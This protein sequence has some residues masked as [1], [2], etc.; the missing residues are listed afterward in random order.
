MNNFVFRYSNECSWKQLKMCLPSFT[1]ENAS[2]CID[3][4]LP[5]C[6]RIRYA[7][8][9]SKADRQYSITNC[10]AIQTIF[11]SNF[12][13]P[14][15]IYL[16]MFQWSFYS[17]VA[18][19]GGTLALWLSIDIIKTIDSFLTAANWLHSVILGTKKHNVEGK[20]KQVK[21]QQLHNENSAV[22]PTIE[23]QSA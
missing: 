10:T 9:G 16:E 2:N 7:L 15:P 23:L 17:F 11:P 5:S 1:V 8:S 21:R 14:V 13:F 18:G 12:Q 4:C 19:L 20:K 22:Q 3:N 6:E